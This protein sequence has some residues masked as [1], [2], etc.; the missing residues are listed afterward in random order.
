MRGRDD[1]RCSDARVRMSIGNIV[2]IGCLEGN[3]VRSP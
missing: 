2:A 1:V 3:M